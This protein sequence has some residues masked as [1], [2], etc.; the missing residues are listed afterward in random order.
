MFTFMQYLR[1]AS[2]RT[3]THNP[4]TQLSAL[5]RRYRKNA[6]Y[7][8]QH[9]ETDVSYVCDTV[10]DDLERVTRQ[11]DLTALLPQYRRH[12]ASETGAVRKEW[13][14]AISDITELITAWPRH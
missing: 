3:S 12:V 13:Q 7:A 14:A 9:G 11:T 8:E 1:E 4:L 5:I 6:A 2:M 10:A